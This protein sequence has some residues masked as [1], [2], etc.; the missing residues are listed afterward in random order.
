MNF[1]EQTITAFIQV[2]IGSS[3]ALVAYFI[4]RAIG[5]VDNSE[6]GINKLREEFGILKASDQKQ[7]DD[8]EELIEAHESLA[9]ENRS[10]SDRLIA[11]E[12][13]QRR[14]KV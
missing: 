11:V 8:L 3:L 7:W 9:R 2:V 4:S 13:T 5:R 10:L 6:K 12:T 14:K 1:E